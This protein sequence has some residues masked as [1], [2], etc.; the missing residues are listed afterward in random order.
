MKNKHSILILSMVIT[1]GLL[2]LSNSCKKNNNQTPRAQVPTITTVA[3]SNITETTASCGGSISSDG[4]SPI[5]AKGVCWSAVTTPTISNPKTTDGTGS[6][7]FSSAITGLTYG[8][9][10]TARAYATNSL[11]TAY[12]NLITFT[13]GNSIVTSP[14]TPI[15]NSIYF[16]LQYDTYYVTAGTNG[17]VYGNYGLVG[18]GLYSDLRIEFSK[19]PASGRFVTSGS[20]TIGATECIVDGTFG[21]TIG[22]HYVASAH[23]TVYVTKNGSGIYSMSFC[24]LHFASGSTSYTFNSDGN[25][26]SN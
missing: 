15:K 24:H 9:T 6:G 21:G 16:N 26:T 1:G 25:L 7:S 11:G 2:I 4:G 14:C 8:I 13:T 19:E 22:Y 23:D 12:G 20:T 17:L 3:I 18:N 5:T 10:Y